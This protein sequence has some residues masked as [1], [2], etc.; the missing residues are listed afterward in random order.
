MRKLPTCILLFFFNKI[1][2]YKA[3]VRGKDKEKRILNRPESLMQFIYIMYIYIYNTIFGDSVNIATH[4]HTQHTRRR[5][6]DVAV[7]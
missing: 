4:V 7:S 3:V 1:N 5:T 2:P 6:P